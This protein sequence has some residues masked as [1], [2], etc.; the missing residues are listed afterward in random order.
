MSDISHPRRPRA[1]L[2]GSGIT[3]I[4]WHNPFL[5]AWWSA[6]FPGFGHLILN[7]YIRGTLLTLTEVIVNTLAHINESMIYT[8]CGRFEAARDI[9]DPRWAFPYLL[10]YM[11]AIWD[12]YRS[13]LQNNKH[14]LLAEL[15]NA[16]LKPFL[17][18][19]MEVHYME[20][21]SPIKAALFSLAFPGFGQLYVHRILLGF[22][23]MVWWF[24]YLG[25]SNVYIAGLR[26]LYGETAASTLILHPHWLLFMPS[27]IGGSIYH[28]FATTIEHNRLFR[29]EQTQYFRE[30]YDGSKL[31]LFPRIG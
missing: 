3:H 10:I 24:I 2:S 4:Q 5:I 14:V 9:L 20:R 6:S 13:A 26:L 27:V 23:A 29:I 19:R 12:S 31:L 8:F 18:G 17:L 30:K 21:K 28:A 22:Y 15:E 11:L 25:L 1:V 7:Q 16:R